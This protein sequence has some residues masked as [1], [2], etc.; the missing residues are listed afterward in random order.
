MKANETHPIYSKT[1]RSLS[2]TGNPPQDRPQRCPW[3]DSTEHRKFQC[4][5]LSKAHRTGVIRL[6]NN[7]QI[8]NG[9]R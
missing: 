8:V 6:N 9:Y 5:E 4:A 7:N 1:P 2:Q 3:C